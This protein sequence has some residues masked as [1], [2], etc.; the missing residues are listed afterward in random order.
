MHKKYSNLSQNNNVISESEISPIFNYSIH[1]N[2]IYGLNWCDNDTKIMTSSADTLT[3]ITNFTQD[4]Y[5]LDELELVG[6]TKRI[7]SN[8]QNIFNNNILATC[9]G[10]GIIFIWDKRISNKRII[11]KN[12]K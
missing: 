12:K 6:H 9:G 8:A 2:A 5:G 1:D 4:K 10:D 7:K 3:K 11:Y